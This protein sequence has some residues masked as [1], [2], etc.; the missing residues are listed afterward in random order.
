MALRCHVTTVAKRI[1]PACRSFSAVRK[2]L[3]PSDVYF[4]PT[5]HSQTSTSTTPELSEE[6]RAVID[7][8]IR[9]DQAGEVAANWIYRGQMA[10]LRNHREA[11]PLIE[12]FTVYLP[13][14]YVNS[15]VW[16]QGHVGAGEEAFGRHEQATVAT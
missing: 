14:P 7:R 16:C 6:H 10:V 1:G 9:V 11:G 3:N 13:E 2:T 15:T 12:V 5:S 4:E 8:A